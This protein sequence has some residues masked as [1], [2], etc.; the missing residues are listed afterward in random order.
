MN[1][2]GKK[3]SKRQK[4]GEKTPVHLEQF[5]EKGYYPD[6]IINFITL[7]GGGFRDRD[8]GS[9]K[10]YSLQELISKFQCTLLKTHSSKIDFENLDI[11]NQNLSRQKLNV[12]SVSQSSTEVKTEFQ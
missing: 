9:D 6:A 3:L 5:R 8:F 10:T 4:G 1:A 12:E 2:D 7:T 11:L